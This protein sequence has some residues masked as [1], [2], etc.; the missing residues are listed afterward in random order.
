MRACRRASRS[1]RTCGPAAGLF[2]LRRAETALAVAAAA[3]TLTKKGRTLAALIVVDGDRCALTIARSDD[4]EP[5]D[6]IEANLFD[7]VGAGHRPVRGEGTDDAHPVV[8]QA[9]A[10]QLFK[11]VGQD[12]IAGRKHVPGRRP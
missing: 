1:T 6:Q 8:A 11:D 4:L 12:A 10:G 3:R 7:H 2:S 5:L 9:S